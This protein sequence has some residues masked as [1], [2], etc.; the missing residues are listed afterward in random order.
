MKKR[1]S[2]T[3]NIGIAMLTLI[4]LIISS[5]QKENQVLPGNDLINSTE[6]K[7]G[8]D[9]PPIIAVPEG[10]RV[11]WHTYA[12]GVQIYQVQQSTTDPN[13]YLWVF[14]APSATL[15][16]DAGFTKPVGTH[17]LGP[18]WQVTKGRKNGGE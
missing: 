2:E 9:V 17:Y 8:P 16:S 14:I 1:I 7:Q 4:A 5:C 12:T 13:L 18:T 15:F 3:K 6:L 11:I 10:N